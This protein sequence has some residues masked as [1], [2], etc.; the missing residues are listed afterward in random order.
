MA[1]TI[2]IIGN[3]FIQLLQMTVLPYGIL[4]LITG[5]GSFGGQDALSLAK[6]GEV[7]VTSVELYLDR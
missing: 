6:K 5:P 7:N 1:K 4:S 2:K 3:A